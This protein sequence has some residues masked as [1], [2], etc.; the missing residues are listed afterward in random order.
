MS[1]AP[2]RD[3]PVWDAG[4]AGAEYPALRGSHAAD[5]VIIGGGYSGLIAAIEA[6]AAGLDVTL[7]EAEQPGAGASSANAGHFAP[8]MLGNSS[9]AKVR[10]SLGKARAARWLEM[11]AG[12]G[13]WL[14]DTI[15]AHDIACDLDRHY[16]C[17]ARSARGVARMRAKFEA[18]RPYG[19]RFE[20]VAPTALAAHVRSG[21]Y[22]GGALLADSGTLNPLRLARGL[23]E[24]AVAKGAAVHGGSRVLTAARGDGGWTVSTA[25]GSV[26]ARR[27]LL[28]TGATGDG[29][30]PEAEQALPQMVAA[31]VA[32]EALADRGA[33]MLPAGGAVVDLDDKAVFSPTITADGR[34]AASFLCAD[35]TPALPGAA[36]PLQRRFARAFPGRDRPAFTQ[37]SSGRMTITPDGVPRILALGEDGWALSGCNGFGLTHG[38]SAAREAARLLAG[39]EPS[40]LALPVLPARRMRGKAMLERVMR[41]VL[42]PMLNRL[43]A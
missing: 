42:V 39:A 7:L 11:L 6:R 40:E 3:A 5:A 21:R 19:G 13:A 23:A 4:P 16:L 29:L 35:A 8:L 1:G 12:S 36:G 26:R 15:E 41:R 10:N 28:A 2:A 17:V 24:A 25:E 38:I 34:L 27:L 31:V 32:T 14:I 37:L 30:F 20:M 22:A 33:A 43:G 9:M 18:W